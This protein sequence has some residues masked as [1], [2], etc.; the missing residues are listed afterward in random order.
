MMMGFGFLVMLLFLG[1]L[2]ALVAGGAVWVARQASGTRT[3]SAPRQPAARQIL[4]ERFAR[5]EISREEYE[6]IRGQLER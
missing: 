4:D 3:P 6:T 2:L 5:G 1:I